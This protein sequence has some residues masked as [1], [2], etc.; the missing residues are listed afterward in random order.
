MNKTTDALSVV[1]GLQ[2]NEELIKLRSENA[3]LTEALAAIIDDSRKKSKYYFNLVWL[4]R[5]QQGNTSRQ[6]GSLSKISLEDQ[7][8]FTRD[9][10][11]L[12]EHARDWHHGFNSGV[13]AASRLYQGLA[14][15]THDI[16]EDDEYEEPGTTCIHTAQN[17]RKEAL[18]EFPMLDT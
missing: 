15:A 17:Q 18:E 13:L 4:A 11:K 6:K 12:T 7:I 10:E 3:K 5:E 1:V 2:T 14:H 8:E 9:V 16:V